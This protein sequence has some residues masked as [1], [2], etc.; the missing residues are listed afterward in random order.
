MILKHREMKYEHQ[1][2]SRFLPQFLLFFS[3]VL[4]KIVFAMAKT[5]AFPNPNPKN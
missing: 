2:F 3:T 4:A 1:S 5:Q